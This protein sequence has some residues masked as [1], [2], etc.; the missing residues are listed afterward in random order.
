MDE[1][2]LDTSLPV[3]ARLPAGGMPSGERELLLVGAAIMLFLAAFNAIKY[4]RS[5]RRF[6][7]SKFRHYADRS[8]QGGGAG[9][10][11]RIERSTETARQTDSISVPGLLVT[12][13][14]PRFIYRG[15]VQ[16]HAG[17][18]HKGRFTF[19]HRRPAA[20]EADQSRR[21][22]GNRPTS[23]RQVTWRALTIGRFDRGLSFEGEMCNE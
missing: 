17:S 22:R 10:G 19:Q 3:R 12:T 4:F 8:E 13:V 23:D 20:P 1:P 14:V 18:R 9:G 5:Y 6:A 21:P 2:E 16:F 11:G 7:S 15:P